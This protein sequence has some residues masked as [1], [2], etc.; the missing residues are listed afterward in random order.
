MENIESSLMVKA[1]DGYN[2]FIKGVLDYAAG[3]NPEGRNFVGEMESDPSFRKAYGDF[4]RKAVQLG[5]SDQEILQAE[6]ISLLVGEDVLQEETGGYRHLNED[7][8][9]SYGLL[10]AGGKTEAPRLIKN[11]RR[12]QLSEF[13]SISTKD[14]PEGLK[15][16]SL[17]EDVSDLER[18]YMDRLE[19]LLVSRFFFVWG[20]TKANLGATLGAAYEDFF[21]F[22]KVA[23]LIRRSRAGKPLG[24]I[25][26]D[27]TEVRRVI[28]EEKGKPK[29][30]R[31]DDEV[32]E[33]IDARRLG[34]GKFARYKDDIRYI[35]RPK[36]SGGR[37]FK[38]SE[39]YMIV[40]SFFRTTE[41]TKL[42]RGTGIIEQ[43]TRCVSSIVDAF[44][45]NASRMTNNRSP[46]GILVLQGG[47]QNRIALE[48]F[49]KLLWAQ[50]MGPQN[51][52]RIPVMALP[53][54]NQAQ[55]LAFHQSSKDMEFFQWASLLFTIICELSGT[56]PEAISL[57]SNREVMTGKHMYE[58]STTG[59]IRKSKD[60]GLR[61]FLSY[62]ATIVNDTEI[63]AE[64]TG[65]RDWYVGFAGID[66]KDDKEK[67][68]LREGELRTFKSL[69]DILK[70]EGLEEYDEL[71][72]GD[73]NIFDIP[74]IANTVVQQVVNMKIQEEQQKAMMEQQQAAM[75]AQGTA[76]TEGEEAGAEA[77]EEGKAGKGT[78][79]EETSEEDQGII[80]EFGKGLKVAWQG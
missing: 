24:M 30:E 67:A 41:R 5:L 65:N 33:V 63:I 25:L 16:Y 51:R 26:F 35:W 64:L 8:L 43:A 23:F 59:A 13:A 1:I 70:E 48:T 53:E 80:E 69:N 74:A 46:M 4:N 68:A 18:Y 6:L 56:P 44:T 57:A 12:W 19:R 58:E 17:K 20:Y 29:Y 27:P 14:S 76:G 2:D 22:D 78:E 9:I 40:S 71:R 36:H 66:V 42:L 45:L 49:K 77:G 47:Q 52:W 72:I 32:E 37:F 31:W 73:I 15:V 50:T 75:E 11:H 54:K 39:R 60:M 62:F 79:Q 28:P 3:G 7:G 10:R 21:D 34:Y 55:W 38:M 61:N